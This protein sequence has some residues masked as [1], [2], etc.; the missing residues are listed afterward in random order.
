MQHV[1]G[2]ALGGCVWASRV[3]VWSLNSMFQTFGEVG[4]ALG[5]IIP[6][7]HVV[8]VLCCI[9]ASVFLASV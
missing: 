1:A 4:I 3:A 7:D 2:P 8:S 6:T 9:I 5:S